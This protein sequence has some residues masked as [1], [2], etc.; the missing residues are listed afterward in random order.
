MAYRIYEM[1]YQLWY[2]SQALVR[3]IFK[4][5]NEFH[6]FHMPY[7][8]VEDFIYHTPIIN[9]I[10]CVF[11]FIFYFTTRITQGFFALLLFMLFDVVNSIVTSVMSQFEEAWTFYY[12]YFH[13]TKD[14]KTF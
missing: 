10:K 7:A 14:T 13:L 4:S 2:I 1:S 9:L 11:S 3:E 5:T 6:K 12:T 8:R